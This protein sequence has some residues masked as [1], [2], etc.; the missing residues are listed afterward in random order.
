MK[1]LLHVFLIGV[2]ILNPVSA[3]LAYTPGP[4]QNIPASGTLSSTTSLSIAIKNVSNDSPAT[5]LDCNSP[6]AVVLSIPQYVEVTF[7]DNSAGYQA[8]VVSTDNRSATANPRFSPLFR[9]ATGAGI[10]GKTEK[11]TSSTGSGAVEGDLITAAPLLWTVFPAAVDAKAYVFTGSMTQE[12][13]VVDRQ[14]SIATEMS[15]VP[16]DFSDPDV[17]GYASVVAGVAGQT[18]TLG[19]FPSAGRTVDNG[20]AYLRLAVNY[21]GMIAQ[22][23]ATSKLTLEIVT[24]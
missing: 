16:K 24:Y 15:P 8:I 20:K 9:K 4:S 3:A 10:V 21:T 22:E 5:S 13:Y 18:G 6:T 1:K 11:A 14:Q 12:A 2:L 17:L 19:S 23:Y 7:N